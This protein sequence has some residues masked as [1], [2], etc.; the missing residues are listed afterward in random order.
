MDPSLCHHTIQAVVEIERIHLTYI[1]FKEDKFL[2][3]YNL[4]TVNS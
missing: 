4:T 2:T 3:Q 1:L